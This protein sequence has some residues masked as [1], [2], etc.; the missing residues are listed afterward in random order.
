VSPYRCVVNGVKDSIESDI[1]CGWGPGC[2]ACGVGLR[3]RSS[4]DCVRPLICRNETMI[5]TDASL[6]R[7][8][9]YVT[10]TLAISGLS[11]VLYLSHQGDVQSAIVS[12]VVATVGGGTPASAVRFVEF[13]EVRGS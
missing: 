13:G 7:V 10:T 11:R 12:S 5:C 9:N 6:G 4:N 1:D 2:T 8:G 3:C